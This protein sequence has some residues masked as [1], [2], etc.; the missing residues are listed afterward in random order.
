MDLKRSHVTHGSSS[1]TDFNLL[2]PTIEID[3]FPPYNV[4]GSLKAVM[5]AVEQSSIQL[6]TLIQGEWVLWC[7][8]AFPSC[9][10]DEAVVELNLRQ[11]FRLPKLQCFV[12][13]CLMF[14]HR[15][16][17][18]RQ[19][20]SMGDFGSYA[21]AAGT[22]YR[23]PIEDLSDKVTFNRIQFP[24][25]RQLLDLQNICFS[26]SGRALY[27]MVPPTTAPAPPLSHLTSKSIR[28]LIQKS[29]LKL[30][31]PYLSGPRSATPAESQRLRLLGLRS[32]YFRRRIAAPCKADRRRC[33]LQR[34]A[35]L[36]GRPG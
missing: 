35:Q 21:T 1:A 5:Q 30:H 24:P 23:L 33:R 13:T 14:K 19:T 2:I 29:R 6:R 3:E 28:G 27:A 25:N 11:P 26:S 12:A 31:P 7:F 16:Q 15:P 32:V 34:Q 4:N 8:R 17:T 9:K 10:G 22:A 20:G 18:F 36:P